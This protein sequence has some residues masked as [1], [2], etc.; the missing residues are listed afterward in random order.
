M[1]CAETYFPPE[2][3]DGGE[4]ENSCDQITRRACPDTSST[5]GNEKT[6]QIDR[7]SFLFNIWRLD[8]KH[9][10]LGEI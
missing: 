3:R 5:F 1:G 7:K 2:R 8:K 10:I 6:A 4:N 9:L